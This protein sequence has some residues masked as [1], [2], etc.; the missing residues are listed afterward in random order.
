MEYSD[1]F[2]NFYYATN[3]SEG[4]KD[5]LGISRVSSP[6]NLTKWD[7]RN[8]FLPMVTTGQRSVFATSEDTLAGLFSPNFDPRQVVYLPF[9]AQSPVTA[10][11]ETKS[12]IVSSQFSPLKLQVEVEA[13]APALVVVAQAFYPAWHV[14]GKPSPLWRANYAFQALAVPAG[15]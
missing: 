9:E 10:G 14:N 7:P 12:R 3:D 2:G 4:L 15:K 5:F 6:T 8:S 11:A 13:E 1:L